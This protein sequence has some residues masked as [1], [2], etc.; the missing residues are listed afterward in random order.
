MYAVV[1]RWRK[2]GYIVAQFVDGI[3][4]YSR[5]G[6]GEETDLLGVYGLDQGSFSEVGDP[7]ALMEYYAALSRHE[8]AEPYEDGVTLNQLLAWSYAQGFQH[9]AADAAKEPVKYAAV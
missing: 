1:E 5:F 8:V 9:G 7:Q 6:I 3:H 2:S 4:G